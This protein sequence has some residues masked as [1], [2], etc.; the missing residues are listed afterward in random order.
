[1]IQSAFSFSLSAVHQS[2]PPPRRLSAFTKT[3]TI[4]NSPSTTRPALFQPQPPHLLTTQREVCFRVPRFLPSGEPRR[5]CPVVKKHLPQGWVL[6][7]IV[8][9]SV[10]SQ[11]KLYSG[12]WHYSLARLKKLIFHI[13]VN[14]SL[15]TCWVRY[16]SWD[17]IWSDRR[18]IWVLAVT[19]SMLVVSVWISFT[20]GLTRLSLFVT[21][22]VLNNNLWVRAVRKWSFEE[23]Y[24]DEVIPV[25]L[26]SSSYSIGTFLD[27]FFVHLLSNLY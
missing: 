11:S 4:Q 2:T 7:G 8:S 16:M 5:T 14:F 20:V 24:I 1:M 3:L 25:F 12:R 27:I 10:S 6:C 26:L 9:Y 19:F 22:L 13:G 23:R 17:V 15:S 21:I 18:S